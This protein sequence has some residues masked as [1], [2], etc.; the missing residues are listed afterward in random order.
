MPRFKCGEAKSQRKWPERARGAKRSQQNLEGHCWSLCVR[1]TWS[2]AY[3]LKRGRHAQMLI[4]A[5]MEHGYNTGQEGN[6]DDLT[7]YGLGGHYA[8]NED[9]SMNSWSDNV[10]RYEPMVANAFSGLETLEENDEEEHH[11]SNIEAQRFYHLLESVR[12]RIPK[13][14]VSDLRKAT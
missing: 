12:N 14:E 5:P 13:Q 10:V 6:L 9:P 2:H 1:I 11:E 7:R 4:T 3:A 8:T